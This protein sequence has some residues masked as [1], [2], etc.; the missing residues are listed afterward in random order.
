MG[1]FLVCLGASAQDATE[2]TPY[3]TNSPLPVAVL[4]SAPYKFVVSLNTASI[5][6]RNVP[7][8]IMFTTTTLTPGSDGV[9]RLTL[10]Q[11]QQAAGAASNPLVR[12]GQLQVEAAKQHRLSVQAQYFPNLSSSYTGLHFNKEPGQ[13]LTLADGRQVPWT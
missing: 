4:P 5:E 3:G 12:L 1:I 7:D 11:A 9:L 2:K 13:V 6:K 10:D 8:R